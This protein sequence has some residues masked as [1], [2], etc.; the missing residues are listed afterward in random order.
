MIAKGA[1]RNNPRQLAVYLMRVERYDTGEPAE[2]LERIRLLLIRKRGPKRQVE[3]RAPA[4]K[5]A[6]AVVGHVSVA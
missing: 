5:V 6:H 3:G 4:A 1:S 2:L